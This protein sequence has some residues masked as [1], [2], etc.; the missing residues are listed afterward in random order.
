[1]IYKVAHV[2]VHALAR[3]F[4]RLKVVGVENVPQEGGVIVAANHNSYFDIPLLGCSLARRADNIA[5]SE[6]FRNRLIASLF[7]ALGGFPVRRGRF[8]RS[9]IAEAVNR[10]RADRLLAIYPEGRRSPDGRLQPAMSGIGLLV[11]KS[12]VK[13][14]PAYMH[15]ANPVRLFRRVTVIFGEP[16]DFKE[17]I[18]LAEKEGVIPK[19]LYARIASKIM[20]HM[21]QLER[22]LSSPMGE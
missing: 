11:T 5:K 1:M 4:F 14:V 20:T 12:G 2:L 15:G 9:A 7:T 3:I 18:D 8:D 17:E 21:T 13:V 22:V 16:L 10:L 19:I 6:L